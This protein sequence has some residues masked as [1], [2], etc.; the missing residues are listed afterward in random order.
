[1]YVSPFII[2]GIAGFV[3]ASVTIFTAAYFYSC[4]KKGK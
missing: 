2:G 3:L 4:K 1:M